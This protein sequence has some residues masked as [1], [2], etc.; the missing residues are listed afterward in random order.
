MAGIKRL[1]AVPV[2][3]VWIALCVPGAAA[4]MGAAG[5]QAHEGAFAVVVAAP[6]VPPAQLV[7]AKADKPLV[8]SSACLAPP[9]ASHAFALTELVLVVDAWTAPPGLRLTCPPLSPRP[10]PAA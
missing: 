6:G 7:R 3:F 8:F 10:P 5:V 2:V 1:Q 9:A 4:G